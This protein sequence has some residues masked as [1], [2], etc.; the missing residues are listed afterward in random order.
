MQPAWQTEA[1]RSGPAKFSR[2]AERRAKER[3]RST[4]ERSELA[5]SDSLD[6]AKERAHG[7]RFGMIERTPC[8]CAD[9]SFLEAKSSRALLSVESRPLARST[10][11]EMGTSMSGGTPGPSKA[12]PS[13]VR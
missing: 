11:G 12:F 2:T 1:R 9:Y 6:G 10:A 8:G 13:L 7:C 4:C 5:S 3:V